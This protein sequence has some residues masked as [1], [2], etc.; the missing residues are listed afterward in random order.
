MNQR[1]KRIGLAAAIVLVIAIGVTA[2]LVMRDVHA[3]SGWMRTQL[4]ECAVAVEAYAL[5]HDGSF[6]E[7]VDQL[8]P[9]LGVS[10]DQMLTHP[11]THE[12]PGF[13]YLRPSGAFHDT[14][15]DTVIFR[16]LWGGEPAANGLAVRLDGEVVDTPAVK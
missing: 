14:P 2:F 7:T 15:K 12:S 6:P 5:D 13:E 11:F 3:K 9:Y 8:Q 4:H 1:L 10:V 16:E